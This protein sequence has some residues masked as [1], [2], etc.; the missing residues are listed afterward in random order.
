MLTDYQLLINIV[1]EVHQ[2]VAKATELHGPMRSRH[3][4]YAVI[5]EELDEVWDEVKKNPMKMG[6]L[7]AEDW[8]KHLRKE[9]IQTAAM[10]VRAIHDLGL[11]EFKHGTS[12]TT[13]WAPPWT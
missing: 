7:Q 9:L 6:K 13:S 1:R 2:E 12:E 4:A 5:L 3:E 11:E 10:C 8:R